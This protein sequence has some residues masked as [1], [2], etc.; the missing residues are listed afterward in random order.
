MRLDF[1]ST[2][3]EY[4]KAKPLWFNRSHNPALGDREVVK[5]LV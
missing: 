3:D 4:F 5:E 1:H 2:L